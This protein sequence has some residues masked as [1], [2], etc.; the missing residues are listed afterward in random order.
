[1][2]S[3]SRQDTPGTVSPRTVTRRP[4]RQFLMLAMAI[5]LSAGCSERAAAPDVAAHH[6]PAATAGEHEAANAHADAAI[7]EDTH[8]AHAAAAPPALPTTPWPSDPPLREGMRRMHRAVEALGHAEHAHLDAAQTAAAAQ[9]V[10][11]AATYMITNCK[12]P[13][14]PDA[15][16]HGVLATLMSGAAA[17]KA[18]PADTTPVAAMREAMAL[19][20]RMFEDPSWQADTQS[21][22]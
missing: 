6:A 18:N 13:P 10:Q 1:M 8:A 5:A 15:A 17:L 3:H 14:E 7:A 12:L 9:H 19:Y 20:P 21:A 22:D 11:D 2:L 16:L 4:A